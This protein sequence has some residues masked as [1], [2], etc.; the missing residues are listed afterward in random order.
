MQRESP[1][2][3]VLLAPTN[4]TL[5]TEEDDYTNQPLK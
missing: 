2:D 3:E 1:E 4:I 5:K